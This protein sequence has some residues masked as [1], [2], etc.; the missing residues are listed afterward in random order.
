M[1]ERGLVL[2][3]KRAISGLKQM[4]EGTLTSELLETEDG[5]WKA[6]PT[7]KRGT[8]CAEDLKRRT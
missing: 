5:G 3:V 2:R 1:K 6:W 8:E 4:Q 7:T